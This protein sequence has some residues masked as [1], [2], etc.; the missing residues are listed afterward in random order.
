[1]LLL[2][3]LLMSLN[4]LTRG[5]ILACFLFIIFC[6]ILKNSYTKD[7]K[8]KTIRNL[9]TFF[10][11]LIIIIGLFNIDLI[12]LKLSH[13]LSSVNI[14]VNFIDE[15]TYLLEN[16]MLLNGRDIIYKESLRLFA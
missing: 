13:L 14:N 2:F 1:I 6:I 11:G 12:F 7:I 10:V 15:M 8:V 4:Y 16:D 5:V 9:L 3:Y